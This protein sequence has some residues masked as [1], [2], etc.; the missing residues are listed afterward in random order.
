[1][2]TS[3]AAIKEDAIREQAYLI[4]ER[5]GRPWGREAEFWDRAAAE[6]AA[7]MKRPRT[8]AKAAPKAPSVTASAKPAKARAPAKA[9]ADDKVIVDP[10]K[11]RAPRAKGRV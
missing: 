6:L 9:K 5:E 7:L 8:A 4:W 2:P 3:N 1:M 10:P 11:A